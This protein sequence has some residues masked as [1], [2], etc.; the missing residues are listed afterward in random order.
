M[1]AT[2]RGIT[3]ARPKSTRGTSG[4]SRAIPITVS[5]KPSRMMPL[6]RRFPD[7]FPARTAVANMLRDRG[8]RHRP[9]CIALYSS[10]SCR[11]IGSTI[12]APPRAICCSICW[13][14]PRRKCG[15][16]NRPGSSRVSLP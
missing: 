4:I 14:M 12:I 8:A 5:R 2:A 15:K 1:P 10:F 9:A 7:F 3:R 11:K 6:G 13:V 16:V